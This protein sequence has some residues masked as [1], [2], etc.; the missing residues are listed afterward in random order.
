LKGSGFDVT[1][2][3]FVPRLYF[4]ARSQNGIHHFR[5]LAHP[6][7]R[8]LEIRKSTRYRSAW[9][10]ENSIGRFNKTAG[11]Q[12]FRAAPVFTKVQLKP[13]GVPNPSGFEGFGF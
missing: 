4:L 7:T 10:E 11:G 8:L 13:A 12:P 3:S 5:V 1:L 6:H 2:F 9:I